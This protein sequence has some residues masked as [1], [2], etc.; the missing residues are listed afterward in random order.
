MKK[1]NLMP[2]NKLGYKLSLTSE[3]WSCF[4]LCNSHKIFDSACQYF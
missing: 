3:N 2:K 4:F 1:Q